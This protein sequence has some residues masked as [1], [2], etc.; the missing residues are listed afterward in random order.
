M[1]LPI[2]IAG[3]W[4]FIFHAF[5]PTTASYFIGWHPSPF[6]FEV[7]AAN[8][9][10]GLLGLFSF[11]ASKGFRHAT[12]LFTTCFLWG[13]AAGHIRQMVIHHNF[14]SGNAG[15]IFYTDITIPI[16]LIVLLI[17]YNARSKH[18]FMTR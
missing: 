10:L 11:H 8:L 14:S 1:L 5:F 6:E 16:V 4:A 13:A 3:L 15:T 2:G 17:L 7:A 9:G 18:V 12:A